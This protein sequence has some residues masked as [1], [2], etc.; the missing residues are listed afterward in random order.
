MAIR[1]VFVGMAASEW[2][3]RVVASAVCSVRWWA[4][5][6]V[7][8]VSTRMEFCIAMYSACASTKH[9]N[10]AVCSFCSFCSM[11]VWE[12]E[13]RV[14]WKVMEGRE[15]GVPSSIVV[16]VETASSCLRVLHVTE[17]RMLLGLFGVLFCEW[18][19]VGL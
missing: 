13:I 10:V 18:L 4:A 2:R 9:V 5:T 3:M 14:G 19:V 11:V 6:R 17:W 8:C 7:R 16:S 12:L 15:D 1:M